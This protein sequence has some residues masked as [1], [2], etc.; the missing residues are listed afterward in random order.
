MAIVQASIVRASGIAVPVD[1]VAALRNQSGQPFLPS[2]MIAEC[3]K[4][5]DPQRNQADDAGIDQHSEH[6][7]LVHD[8][9]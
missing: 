2:R 4:V 9:Q 7:P 8:G 5:Q 3:R 1:D 6:Q